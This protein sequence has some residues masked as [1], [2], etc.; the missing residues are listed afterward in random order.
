VPVVLTRCAS[1][2]IHVRPDS[3]RCP[4]CGCSERSAKSALALAAGAVTFMAGIGCAYGDA[5]GGGSQP[6]VFDSGRAFDVTIENVQ[7][8]V[9]SEKTESAAD[10]PQEAS[11]GSAKDVSSLDAPHDVSTDTEPV[12]DA[13]GQ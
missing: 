12:K 2:G 9:S 4:F 7:L 1:C 6:Y 11:E 8:D 3:P 10:A 13:S 5:G